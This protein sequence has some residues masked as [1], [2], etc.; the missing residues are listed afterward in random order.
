MPKSQGHIKPPDTVTTEVR[1]DG[2]LIRLKKKGGGGSNT[3]LEGRF[4]TSIVLLFSENNAPTNM[5]TS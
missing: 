4:V 2:P 5:R 1:F 3:K